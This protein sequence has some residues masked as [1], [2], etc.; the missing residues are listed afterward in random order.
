[1]KTIFVS[2]VFAL[3][4]PTAVYADDDNFHVGGRDD[5]HYGVSGDRHTSDVED[6]YAYWSIGVSNNHYPG[7]LDAVLN[8]LESTPGVN[9][10]QLALDM[11]GFYWPVNNQT[12]LGFVISGSA[13]R[14]ED[15]YGDY[16]QLNHYLYGLSSMHFFGKTIGDGFYV[17]G[18]VGIAKINMDSNFGS[19][20]SDNGNGFL[21]G[22]G[23]GWP[24]SNESRILVG[25]TTS[26]YSV[27]SETY[28][29]TSL[30][31]GGLW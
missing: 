14:F 19:A 15:S 12:I 18:D 6:W 25:L 28:T 7:S 21:L 1:M 9:R 11:L 17:R 8:T 22:I 29:T 24:I 27:E 4:I 20:T 2:I 23:Y 30:T 10:T 16:L 26:S 3:L 5:R 13:D 31:V